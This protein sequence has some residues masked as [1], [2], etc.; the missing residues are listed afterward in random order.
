MYHAYTLD[1]NQKATKSENEIFNCI[2]SSRKKTQSNHFL[3][4]IYS[5]LKSMYDLV[6]SFKNG[7]K[8]KVPPK[9]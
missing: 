9:I 8:L 6:D 4:T 5:W 2:P 7:N 3:T 1:A